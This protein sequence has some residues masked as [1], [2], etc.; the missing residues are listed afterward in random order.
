[1]FFCEPAGVS[2][3]AKLIGSCKSLKSIIL[4]AEDSGQIES[5]EE[6][7]FDTGNS[8]RGIYERL[9]RSIAN[10]NGLEELKVNTIHE[11]NTFSGGLESLE[12]PF[13]DLRYLSMKD[14]LETRSVSLL[15]SKL[16]PHSLTVL[17]LNPVISD[18]SLTINPLPQ[19]GLLATLQKLSLS[20]ED[21]TDMGFEGFRPI[22]ML[23]L[24]N[25]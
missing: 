23:P 12:Q 21:E 8:A 24:K 25:L 2:A 7:E 9:L 22:D 18:Y 10:C 16:N 15:L 1:M 14:K 11:Y 6:D 3:L 19:I 20:F 4:Y 5:S 13:K 17:R